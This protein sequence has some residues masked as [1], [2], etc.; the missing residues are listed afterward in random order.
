M[1][2]AVSA[3]SLDFVVTAVYGDDDCEIKSAV[4]EQYAT[5]VVH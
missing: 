1:Q 4:T 3:R 2:I 5:R